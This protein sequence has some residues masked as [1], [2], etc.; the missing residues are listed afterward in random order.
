MAQKRSFGLTA[1]HLLGLLLAASITL[2]GYECGQG[3]YAFLY[4]GIYAVFL[5]FSLAQRGLTREPNSMRVIMTSSTRPW[6]QK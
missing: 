6:N 5:A 1:F 3:A 4:L 2:L